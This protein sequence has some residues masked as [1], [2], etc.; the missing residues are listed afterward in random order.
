MRPRGGRAGQR[1]GE[2]RA[3]LHP[4]QP[5]RGC[6]DETRSAAVG[7]GERI[8]VGKALPQTVEHLQGMQARRGR[9]LPAPRQHDLLKPPVRDHPQRPGHRPAKGVLP[10]DLRHRHAFGRRSGASEKSGAGIVKRPEFAVRAP[11]L[12]GQ[13]VEIAGGFDD[14]VGHGDGALRR[15]RHLPARHKEARG[16]KGFAR[17]HVVEKSKG[18][19]K[20]RPGESPSPSAHRDGAVQDVVNK[21]LAGGESPRAARLERQHRLRAGQRP[22]LGRP[23]GV[24]MQLARLE[25]RL[26]HGQG[27]ERLDFKRD[28]DQAGAAIPRRDGAALAEKSPQRLGRGVGGRVE[29]QDDHSRALRGQLWAVR[30]GTAGPGAD[31]RTA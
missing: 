25:D 29:R 21:P 12:R 14:E 9:Q 28:A 20:M 18:P 17:L 1:L 15:A 4:Q 6:A 8:A 22:A 16:R 5:F 30:S 11:D 19:E 7:K 27:I 13:R 24:E 2:E 31:R 26:E 3:L 23:L 10:A